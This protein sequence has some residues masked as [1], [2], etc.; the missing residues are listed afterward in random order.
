LGDNCVVNDTITFLAA[1]KFTR[2]RLARVSFL[3]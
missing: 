1:R 2:L 3:A